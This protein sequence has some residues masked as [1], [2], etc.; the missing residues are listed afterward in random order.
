MEEMKEEKI[1]T[2]YRDFHR[3]QKYIAIKSVLIR[4]IRGK[5]IMLRLCYLTTIIRLPEFR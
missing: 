4:E 3:L 5:K 1:A 2:D